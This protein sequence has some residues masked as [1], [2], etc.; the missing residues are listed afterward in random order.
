MKY[1][2]LVLLLFI[3]ACSSSK[4][5]YSY[6]PDYDKSYERYLEKSPDAL[7]KNLQEVFKKAERNKNYKVPPGA[8][9]EYGYILLKENNMDLASKYFQKE[10]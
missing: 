10:I 3:V 6:E 9:L 1:S 7:K 8:Y 2:I 4:E 5:L